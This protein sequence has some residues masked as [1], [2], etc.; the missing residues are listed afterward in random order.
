MGKYNSGSSSSTD[1]CSKFFIAAYN[2]TKYSASFGK[3]AIAL[4]TSASIYGSGIK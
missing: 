4:T 1:K 2:T 3:L